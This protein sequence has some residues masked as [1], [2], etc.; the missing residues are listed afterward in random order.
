GEFPGE[1]FIPRLYTIHVLLLPAI[2]LALIAAHLFLVFLHKHTQYPGPGRTNDN[3]VGYPLLPVYVA[4]AGGFFFIVFGVI[5]LIA[6]FVQINPVWA[7]GPYDPSPVTAG[8]QP[9]WYMGF[10]EGAI[11]IMP[12]W[13]SHIGNTTWSWNVAIPGLGLMGLMAVSMMVYPFVEQW[14]T[15]DKSEHH[16]LDRPRNVPTR[17]AFGVAAMTCYGLFWIGG[18]N[19]L[20]ATQFD[21]SLNSVTYFLRV[22]VFVG[23]VI[24]FIITKR[25]CIGLQR[26]DAERLLHGSESA[27]I[28]RDPSGGYSE[29][30]VPIDQ[31][32]AYT[33]TQ[34]V[35]PLP[36]APVTEQGDLSDKELKKEQRRRKATR[37]WYLDAL[38]KPTRAELEAA[39]HHDDDHGDGNGH[40][41]I[42]NGNGH[43]NGHGTQEIGAGSGARRAQD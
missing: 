17:T 24:A 36:L 5:A 39:A 34:H 35:E 31:E 13:E 30:H 10:V 15:G 28:V 16:I 20:I 26:A 21:V 4:K 6:A 3:V 42:G 9:D 25:I 40:G 41:E 37:F 2:F 38:R 29:A 27:I 8:S 14:V 7:Y 19:D 43:G 11:R 32:E 22:M 1:A 12:N 18:G 33:L 23:P